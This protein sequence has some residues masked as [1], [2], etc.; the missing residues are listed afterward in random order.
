MYVKPIPNAMNN[1]RPVSTSM[2]K[3][4]EWMSDDDEEDD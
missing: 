4:T 3:V 1:Q 2:Y